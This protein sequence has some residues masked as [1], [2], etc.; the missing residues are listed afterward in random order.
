MHTE[1]PEQRPGQADSTTAIKRL[2]SKCADSTCSTDP[3]SF[4]SIEIPL[5]RTVHLWY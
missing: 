3:A 5:Y 2:L 4:T 1:N